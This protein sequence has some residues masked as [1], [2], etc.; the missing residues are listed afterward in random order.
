[1]AGAFGAGTPIR[2]SRS[3]FKS[4]SQLAFTCALTM[5]MFSGVR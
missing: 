5:A 3:N 4:R 1:M 2:D